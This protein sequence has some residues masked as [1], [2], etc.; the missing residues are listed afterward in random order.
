MH[1]PF[2]FYHISVATIF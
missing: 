2:G 1:E